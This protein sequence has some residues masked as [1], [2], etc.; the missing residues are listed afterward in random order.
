MKRIILVALAAT[1]LST[2]AIA[3]P[4][5]VAGAI[6]NCEAIMSGKVPV[7]KFVDNSKLD[8]GRSN[9]Q[10]LET[11][12]HAVHG[13]SDG[14]IEVARLRAQAASEKYEAD[15]RIAGLQ[16]RVQDAQQHLDSLLRNSYNPMRK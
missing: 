9:P 15:D 2:A 12:A 5:D 7:P 8:Y 3:G 6:P 13:P 10:T 11:Q 4:C 16:A 1:A 14:D